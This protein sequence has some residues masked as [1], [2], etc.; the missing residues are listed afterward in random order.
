MGPEGRDAAIITAVALTLALSLANSSASLPFFLALEETD[1]AF[2]SIL[3]ACLVFF[4]ASARILSWT[5]PAFLINAAW[6][7]GRG[8]RSF[9]PANP[10]EAVSG[11]RGLSIQSL[12]GG[13]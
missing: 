7:S 2:P 10:A 1:A 3:S 11:G 4:R 8:N 5:R 12:P 6:S 9:I 13:R